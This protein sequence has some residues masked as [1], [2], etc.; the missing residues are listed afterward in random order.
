LALGELRASL[1]L[2]P[3]KCQVLRQT[4]LNQTTKALVKEFGIHHGLISENGIKQ[5]FHVGKIKV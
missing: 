3:R 1:L 4:L 5:L 2:M